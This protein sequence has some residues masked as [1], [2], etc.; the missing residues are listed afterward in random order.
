VSSQED[1]LVVF[2]EKSDDV[3]R[4]DFVRHLGVD[5]RQGVVQQE[6]GGI[7]MGVEGSGMSKKNCLKEASSSRDNKSPTSLYCSETSF[8][9]RGAAGRD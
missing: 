1:G 9:I 3:L 4:E 2:P 6:D 5:R 7:G 8:G